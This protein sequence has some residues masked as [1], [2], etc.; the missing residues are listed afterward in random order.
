MTNTQRTARANNATSTRIAGSAS[1]GP[2]DAC[3]HQWTHPSDPPIARAIYAPVIG[4]LRYQMKGG[5]TYTCLRCGSVRV[6]PPEP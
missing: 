2:A 1:T 4:R 6:V 5:E 3:S